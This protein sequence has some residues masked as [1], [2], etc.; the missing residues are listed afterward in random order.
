MHTTQ[1]TPGFFLGAFP[2]QAYLVYTQAET[3][4][5]GRDCAGKS[6]WRAQ[7]WHGVGKKGGYCDSFYR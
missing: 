3:V 1:G 6:A 5:T 4:G 7:K 2:K